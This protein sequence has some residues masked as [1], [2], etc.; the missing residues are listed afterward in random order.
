MASEDSLTVWQLI[1]LALARPRFG[2]L[3]LSVLHSLLHIVAQELNI[4]NCKVK[5]PEP[6]KKV[7]FE[8]QP[9][10]PNRPLVQ[11]QQ[12]DKNGVLLPQRD[13]VCEKSFAINNLPCESASSDEDQS[14]SG[15]SQHGRRSVNSSDARITVAPS[16]V[17]LEAIVDTE[18][19]VDVLNILLDLIA[20]ITGIERGSSVH[21]Q[22]LKQLK[23]RNSGSKSTLQMPKPTSKTL[24][25]SSS[26]TQSYIMANIIE[27]VLSLIP[28]QQMEGVNEIMEVTSEESEPPSEEDS[29]FVRKTD[30]EELVR[31]ILREYAPNIPE[32]VP[33]RPETPPNIFQ[34]IQYLI[35]N[36]LGENP[37]HL[38]QIRDYSETLTK[39]FLDNLE[40]LVENLLKPR[41]SKESSAE[42]IIERP[43]SNTNVA[44]D[45]NVS[46]QQIGSR[47][48]IDQV[49]LDEELG[50]SNRRSKKKNKP[51][52]KQK[53]YKNDKENAMPIRYCG[54]AH[55]I[56]A[57]AERVF[58]KQNFKD[59]YH[60]LV[61]S[62]IKSS[63]RM[64]QPIR[65]LRNP[66]NF[67]VSGRPLF[68]NA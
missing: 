31:R 29:Q 64:K 61:L 15:S 37:D 20:D 3:N 8:N 40:E 56:I 58:R 7:L 48:E 50:E 45:S 32:M 25:S 6:L 41:R 65:S 23:K 21:I 27:P 66:S 51:K 16:G 54:G 33:A 42:Q 43:R 26:M 9:E 67:M 13:V 11:I 34:K 62:S 53:L 1:D 12:C 49:D 57:P 60:D 18:S 10:C 17:S 68:E 30:L 2:I 36:K 52:S 46:L 5:I 63:N 47:D 44:L 28:F 38:L 4:K 19:K 59:T 35:N 39:E 55:T 14:E 24:V 22:T